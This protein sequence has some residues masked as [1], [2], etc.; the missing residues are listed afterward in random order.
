MRLQCSVVL[1]VWNVTSSSIYPPFTTWFWR[2]L[3]NKG[4]HKDL[5]CHKG[6][7]KGK[8]GEVQNYIHQVPLA[9]WRIWDFDILLG[10]SLLRAL[11]FTPLN[12]WPSVPVK[13]IQ[14]WHPPNKKKQQKN[15]KLS[16]LSYF[17]HLDKG[18]PVTAMLAFVLKVSFGRRRVYFR[19]LPLIPWN[20]DFGT[21]VPDAASFGV[22]EHHEV[23]RSKTGRQ[24]QLEPSYL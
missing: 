5:I 16:Q 21:F 22:V 15:R 4:I 18:A 2:Q 13:S 3:G 1:R 20:I 7:E 9:S 10:V 8:C 24:S 6:A 12:F 14:L 19:I 11:V 23:R 17:C